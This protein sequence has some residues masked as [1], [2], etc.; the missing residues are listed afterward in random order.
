MATPA[1]KP[2]T[3]KVFKGFPVGTLNFLSELAV[4]NNRDWFHSNKTR[5]VNDCVEPALDLIE[6]IAPKLERISPYFECIPK[7]IGGSLFRIYR[8]VRFSHDKRPYK[9]NIGIHFRHEA[10]KDAH[11]PGFYLHIGVDECFL[12]AGIWRPAGDTLQNIRQRIVEKPDDWRKIK[13][14]RRFAQTF[15]MWGDSLKRPPRG[16]DKDHPLVED[17]KRKDFIAVHYFD[18]GLIHDADIMD[19]AIETYGKATLLMAFLCR[20]QG[21]RF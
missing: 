6:T 2:P 8:D 3:A 4:N 12:G 15:Q 1:K 20:S 16:F 13:R 9:T 10:A 19:Y 21:V 14:G 5:Y 7:R 17:L 18:H 11:A